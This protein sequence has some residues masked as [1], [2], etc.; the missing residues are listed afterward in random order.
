MGSVD[1]RYVMPHNW[2]LAG[3]ATTTQ[4]DLGSGGYMAGPGYIASLKKSDNHLYFQN[5]YTDRSPGLNSTLGYIS[6]TDIRRLDSYANYQWKPTKSRAVMAYGPAAEGIVI[7]DHEH[8]LQNWSFMD[9]FSITL[10]RLTILSLSHEEAY[11]LYRDIGF[12][13][14]STTLA[15]FTSWYKW[16][17]MSASYSIG[18]QPNYYPAKGISPFLAN[19]VNGSAIITLH[20]RTH[21]RLDEI[22]YYTRLAGGYVSSTGATPGVI[23]TNHL[24]R[25]KIN[26]QFT[27]DYSFNAIFDYNALLPNNTFVAS[28]YSKQADTTLLFTYLPHPGTALYVGYSDTFQ[29]IDYSADA[30]PAYRLTNMPGT[31]TDRQ[32]FVKFSYLLRF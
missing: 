15:M 7:Y 1:L 12:R 16:L 30:T 25:S 22:Y 13:D 11:E 5:V 6:R 18:T 21:L 4:T 29:N 27:R 28:T 14:H 17:D 24:I 31:S 19:W 3:Q 32:V 20:P 23:F 2:T 9:G 10:P 8:R 26:Y